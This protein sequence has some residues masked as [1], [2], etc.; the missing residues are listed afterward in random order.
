MKEK[1]QEYALL[2]EIISAICIVLSLIFVGF[3]VRQ[4]AEET[5][6]NTEAL[7]SQVRESM[8]NADLNTLYKMMDYPYLAEVNLDTL[9]LSQEERQRARVFYFTMSRSRENFW[10]QHEAGILDTTT[11]LS[12]RGTFIEFLTSSELYM[13]VWKAYQG[14]LTPGFQEEINSVLREQG[15]DIP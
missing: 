9:E 1:L 2:A 10:I 12:Y 3:Q 13:N 7:R 11:Y 6:A 8:L 4:G 5:A 14:A 15:I